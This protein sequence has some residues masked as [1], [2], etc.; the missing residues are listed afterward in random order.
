MERL[1]L[2]LVFLYTCPGI[3]CLYYGTEQGFDGGRDPFDREDMFAGQFEWGP[4]RGDNFD[5]TH[6]LFQWVARLNNFR[7]LYPA[8]ELGTCSILWSDPRGPGLF[9]CAR[10]LG[11][12]EVLVI[13]N[14]ADTTRILPGCAILSPAGTQMRN[15]LD[16]RQGFALLAGGLT[17]P[18][19]LKGAS[20]QIFINQSQLRSLDPVVIR[21]SPAH[22]ATNVALASSLAIQFN[23]PMDPRTVERAFSLAPPVEGTFAWSPAGDRVEFRPSAGGAPPE[24]MMT[25]KISDQAQAAVTG[26]PLHAAFESRFKTGR[27]GN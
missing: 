27:R 9:A 7:R 1:K 11:Q 10:R 5:M 21:I 22:D 24:T 12:Q 26:L 17:P 20:A 19:P 8:L 6:P 23:A 18:L 2:A 13:F 15:L 16:P 3:P 14:T 25:V 4:S